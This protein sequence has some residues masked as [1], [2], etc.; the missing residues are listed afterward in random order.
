MKHREKM[1]LERWPGAYA[2]KAAPYTWR[3]NVMQDDGTPLTIS[4]GRTK[5]Q[6]WLIASSLPNNS[7]AALDRTTKE[8]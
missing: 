7:S 2:Y 5:A 1:V 4:S 8:G 3:I 6:A